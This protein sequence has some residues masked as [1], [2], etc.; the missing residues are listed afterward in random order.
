MIV[1][2]ELFG[3]YKKRQLEDDTF[4][5]FDIVEKKTSLFHYISLEV[6]KVHY[7]QEKSVF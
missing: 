7:H 3:L 1:N 5:I 2:E 4:D 6:P